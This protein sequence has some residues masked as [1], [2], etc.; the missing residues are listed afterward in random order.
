MSANR[1]FQ[2]LSAATVLVS[3]EAPDEATAR[4][5]LV[6]AGGEQLPVSVT[7]R[8]GHR[9]V[10]LQLTDDSPDLFQIDGVEPP[11]ECLAEKCDG[12]LLNGR[13]TEANCPRACL[14]EDCLNRTDEDR[15]EC[16]ACAERRAD[17]EAGEHRNGGNADCAACRQAVTD[18]G[19]PGQR[20]NRSPDSPDTH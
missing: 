6:Q 11:A 10:D 18:A 14:N 16:G 7:T 8:A 17:H 3:V 1:T 5:L 9:I 4:R 13:C 19:V 15:S 2:F 20:D 12:F